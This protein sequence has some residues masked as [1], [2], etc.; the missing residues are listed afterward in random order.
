MTRIRSVLDGRSG[1]HWTEGFGQKS[2]Q[3]AGQLTDSSSTR[4]V[5]SDRSGARNR[6]GGWSID[7]L[8]LILVRSLLSDG[9]ERSR[10][11]AGRST[12]VATASA[13]GWAAPTRRRR[14]LLHPWLRRRRHELLLG[15][16]KCRSEF[17]LHP[18]L[19][20]CGLSRRVLLFESELFLTRRVKK[21]STA[22]NREQIETAEW[23]MIPRSKGREKGKRQGEKPHGRR[24]LGRLGG[25]G[26]LRLTRLGGLARLPR[27]AGLARLARLA[28]AAILIFL[29]FLFLPVL[30][31]QR[32]A[33]LTNHRLMNQ[34]ETK[35]E[36]K[37]RDKIKGAQWPS[38]RIGSLA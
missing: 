32:R 19:L 36:N 1:Q 3:L 33:M 9:A 11:N 29:L 20:S 12:R 17:L 13:C 37:T 30:S 28:Q 26:R 4:T 31:L 35:R 14:Y 15:R 18:R 23:V 2:G 22:T 24:K 6:I 16:I 34:F 38:S 21:N 7:Q 8:D 5:L 10:D 25:L 27:L